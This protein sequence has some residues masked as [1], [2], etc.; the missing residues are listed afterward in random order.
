MVNIRTVFQCA[1]CAVAMLAASANAQQYPAKAIR[2]VVPF[3]PGGP[4][5]VLGRLVGQKLTQ[6]W[7]QSVVV[8]NRG[9]AGGTIGLEYAARLP[10]DGYA[11]AMGGS[12]NLTVAPSLYKKLSYDPQKDFSPIIN[13]AHVPYA[14]AVNP[15]VPARNVKELLAI[16]Q[17]KPGY[18][19]YGSSGAGSM[20]SLAA[21]LLKSMSRTS[22]VHVSY[23]GT[24][25]ALTDVIAGNIDMMLAD[26]A[27]IRTHAAAGKLKALGV[28][29]S[30]RLVS[31]PDLPT[32]DESGLKGYVIEPWFGVV[33]P[34]GIPKDIVVRLNKTIASSLKAGD[35]LQRLGALGYEPIG[36][37]PEQF[38]ATIKADIANYARIVKAA[39]IAAAM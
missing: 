5:D 2:M 31:A 33:G 23:K 22:I 36:G 16:A 25:P 3:A 32:I 35:V 14:L 21:E 27:V 19:S 38:A 6:E 15:I 8:E 34:A 7:G 20:S 10:A 17:R 9:G 12:S 4:N 18:L 30:K 29:G 39:G 1:A 11:I 24:A 37:T 28:T 13:V 26:F